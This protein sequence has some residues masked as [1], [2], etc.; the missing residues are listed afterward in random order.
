MQDKILLW[1]THI[2]FSTGKSFLKKFLGNGGLSGLSGLSVVFTNKI[3]PHFN[4]FNPLRVRR[5]R[6]FAFENT[7]PVE[8]PIG[9]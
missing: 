8:N 1:F 2:T 7:K 5:A 4:P 9:D 6:L 3:S